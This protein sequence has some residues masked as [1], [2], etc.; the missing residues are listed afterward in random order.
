M[1]ARLK[2]I[3]RAR[4]QGEGADLRGA[5]LTRA[6]LVRA[7]LHGADLSGADLRQAKLIEADLTGANLDGAD[8]REANLCRADLRQSSLKRAIFLYA[9]LD[10][11][12]LRGAEL[13]GANLARRRLE[14]MDLSDLNLTDAN[15][16]NARLRH[17][18][19]CRARLLRADLSGAQLWGAD[20]TDAVLTGTT[21][22]EA[23]YSRDT[24]WPRGFEPANYRA[25]GPTAKVLVAYY[26]YIARL[27]EVNLERAHFEVVK[28]PELHEVLPKARSEFPDAIVLSAYNSPERIVQAL[29]SETSLATVP[30]IVLSTPFAPAA[31]VALVQ[32]L[33]SRED[34]A[35]V[36][37]FP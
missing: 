25:I 4:F 10:G 35:Q 32:N 16:S 37:T 5:L 11:V 2:W 7:K 22:T 20:L 17:A 26:P 14:G 12:D 34:E 27:I 3:W 30:V 31:F 21:L 6:P 15:L 23:V 18:K 24:V 28:A 1:L 13:E 9:D 33:V 19:L 8:L 36:V 29:R